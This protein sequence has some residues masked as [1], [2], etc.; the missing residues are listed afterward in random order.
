MAVKNESEGFSVEAE[1]AK[2]SV[3]APN[4]ECYWTCFRPLATAT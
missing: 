1:G 2:L 4:R 3:E